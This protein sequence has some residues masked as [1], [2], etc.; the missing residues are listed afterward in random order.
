MV[1]PK[2]GSATSHQIARVKNGSSCRRSPS[3]RQPR[4][5]RRH[6]HRAGRTCDRRLRRGQ[7][8]ACLDPHLAPGWREEAGKLEPGP[9]FV[10]LYLGLEGD[11]AA[12]GATSAKHWICESEEI[13]R[14]RRQ[15][16]DE[17]APG[18]F[19]SFQS[20]KDPAWQGPSTAEVLALVELAAFARWLKDPALTR[21]Y[22]AFKEW[23]ADRL[24]AQFKRHFPALG[25][26]VRFCEQATPLTRQR[27]VHAAGGSMYGIEQS[28][29]LRHVPASVKSGPTSFRVEPNSQNCWS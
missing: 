20:L 25:P 4:P 22:Q 19:V 16:A 5:P 14:T 29:T 23:V 26:M 24:F 8:A 28:A 21:D 27:F 11:I 2:S 18:L 1:C 12:A 13:S 3:A 9:G 10:A 17:D 7:R 15:P 6:E